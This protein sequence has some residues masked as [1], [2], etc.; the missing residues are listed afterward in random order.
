MPGSP[1]LSKNKT[2]QVYGSFFFKKCCIGG[3][4]TCGWTKGSPAPCLVAARA[5]RCLTGTRQYIGE[6][7]VDGRKIGWEDGCCMRNA[8]CEGY[9][10]DVK[11]DMARVLGA[12]DDG[13]VDGSWV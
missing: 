4:L 3:Y 2:N 1:W 6:A 11:E 10:M 9:W 5:V 12:R 8:E 13:F 7:S